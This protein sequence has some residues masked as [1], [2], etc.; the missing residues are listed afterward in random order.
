MSRLTIPG[1]ADAPPQT[2][3]TLDAIGK[4][5]GFIP[6]LHRL[7]AT[8]PAVLDGFL[9][10]QS[11]LAKT[12]DA[13]TRHAISLAVSAVNGCEYCLSAHSYAAVTFGKM[14]GEEIALARQGHSSDPK[15]DAATH[16]ARQVTQSRG[17]VSDTDL[18]AVR[19]AG[20]TDRQIVEIV[21]LSAQFLMTNFLNNVAD[22]EIDFPAH[23]TAQATAEA[24]APSPAA[25][26]QAALPAT[27]VVRLTGDLTAPPDLTQADL[28]ALPQQNVS[29]EFESGQGRQSHTE[30]GVLLADL[31]PVDALATT[32]RKN[33]AL[34]F[35]VVAVGADGYLALV[36]YGEIS[37]DFGNRGA[38][39][40]TSEDGQALERPRLVVPGDVKGGRYVS[41]LVALRV[42]RAA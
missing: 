5:L 33:D 15:R 40:A 11:S 21:A 18:A 16:F 30:Q 31:L 42:V 1:R 2:Q 25:A 26:Q 7:M 23:S 17:K 32:D 24:P 36:S 34:S 39:L 29:V 28:A 12:L 9:A 27:G 14:T 37:P 3:P 4:P 38:L 19:A 10:L 22:T 20:Y 13:A 8:S 35:G 6:N 41:D